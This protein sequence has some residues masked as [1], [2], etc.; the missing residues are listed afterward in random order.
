MV[1]IKG[2]N[3]EE[4]VKQAWKLQNQEQ[5]QTSEFVLKKRTGYPGKKWRRRKILECENDFFLKKNNNSYFWINI[6]YNSLLFFSSK[7]YS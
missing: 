3:K 4:K 7:P 1:Y 2:F 6:C 5:V